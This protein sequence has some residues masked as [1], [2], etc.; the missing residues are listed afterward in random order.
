MIRYLA[1]Y[2]LQCMLIL[3]LNFLIGGCD[4]AKGIILQIIVDT[5]VN[6]K[7]NTL[8]FIIIIGIIVTFVVF[9]FSISLIEP[10]HA[11]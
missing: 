1:K 2:K 10:N 7:A 8:Q 9:H 11:R 3:I 5:S 4:V 6:R